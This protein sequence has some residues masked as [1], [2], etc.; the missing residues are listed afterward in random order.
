M[1]EEWDE[2][3]WEE[4]GY[5]DDEGG[6]DDVEGC[7]GIC[8]PECPYWGGD[9]ICMLAVEEYAGHEE[10][11]EREHVYDAECPVCHKELKCYEVFDDLWEWSGH[12]LLAVEV[13]GF[14]STPKGVL[15][16]RGNVFHIW[17]G[18]GENR[19]ER[20]IKVLKGAEV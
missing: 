2:E 8:M 12:P 11:Y 3:Y 13:Y 14:Y 4:E 1:S 16:S 19:E 18:E 7:D 10:E 15:H 17:I 6:W 9:G 20:L 5:Y